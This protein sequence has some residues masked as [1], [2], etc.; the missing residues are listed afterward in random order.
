MGKTVSTNLS[1]R[2]SDGTIRQLIRDTR[3]GDTTQGLH[4]KTGSLLVNDSGDF[5]AD[6]KSFV[7]LETEFLI[8][9][10]FCLNG[11]WKKQTCLSLLV[12]Y[13]DIGKLWVRNIDP[14]SA[15]TR[16]NYY[17]STDDGE[18]SGYITAILNPGFLTPSITNP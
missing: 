16:V 10:T 12:I 14:N 6:I 18:P 15:L 17:I 4:F 13:G 3:V 11:E 7:M 5:I 9:V 2:L 8:E 1:L